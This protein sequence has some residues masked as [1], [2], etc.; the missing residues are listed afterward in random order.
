[1][2]NLAKNRVTF[3]AIA[4]FLILAVAVAAIF[5]ARGFK[6][7]LKNGKIE[8]T[9]LIVATSIPTGAQVYLDDR[10]TSATNTNIGYLDPKTYRIRIEKDGYT[11]W[12]KEIL[13]Q[14]DLA[15]EIK[16]LLFPVAPEIKP[17]STTGAHNPT[18]SPDGGQIAYGV[19]GERGGAYILSMGDRPFPF[20]Q[21]VRQLTQNRGTI[22]YSKAT[23]I[24]SPDSN[25]IIA[26]I[27]GQNDQ[28][29][30]N[31]LLEAGRSNQQ[32][33]DITA[34]LNAT[35]SDWQ[36]QI[37]AKDQTRVIPVPDEVKSAT[38]GAQTASPSPSPKTRQSPSDLSLTT[39]HLSLNY[40]PTGLMLSPDE[41]K[42]LYKNKENKY[43]V[44]DL[45]TKKEFTLP[46]FS[47]FI[48]IS[49]YPDSAHLV[50]AQKD[51]IS[52]IETDGTNKMTVYSGNF[53]NPDQPAGGVFAHPS[54]TRL[55][56]LTTLTQTEGSP[57]NLYSI[58]LR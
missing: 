21:D 37:D 22:D 28:I 51:L 19:T 30:S 46:D 44:Y 43:K 6:P 47:D 1:M 52:I 25:Q 34:S 39:S 49:W 17:L 35:I 40:F 54:G 41:E 2:P 36:Q 13:V 4:A 16:A 24:W 26:R 10:L 50:V 15:T 23:F 33:N 57:P 11:S 18:L 27:K 32:P 12:E 7:D 42:V 31:L 56:I 29:I 9:G 55:I 48:N 38:A 3:S 5:W 53:E 14:A 45:K 58:N 8:R 20:R